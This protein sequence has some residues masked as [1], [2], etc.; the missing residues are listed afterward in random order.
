MKY[1]MMP[2]IWVEDLHEALIAQYG[3]DFLNRND[4][5]RNIL[6]DDQY[7]NDVAKELNIYDIEK[8]DDSYLTYEWFDERQWRIRNCVLAFLQDLFPNQEYVMIDVTW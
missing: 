7:C 6:F 2:V 3:P 4:N 5:L 8:W 1:K